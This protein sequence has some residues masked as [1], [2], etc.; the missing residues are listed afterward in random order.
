MERPPSPVSQLPPV[1]PRLDLLQQRPPGSHSA[2]GATAKVLT[3]SVQLRTGAAVTVGPLATRQRCVVA[4]P[5]TLP[6]PQVSATHRDKPL[7]LPPALRELP[8]PPP[9]ERP[10]LGGQDSRLQRRPLPS[11]PDQP[12][13]A[14]NYMVPRP[15]NKV[16]VSPLPAAAAAHSGNNGEGSKAQVA[17]NAVYCLSARYRGP[18]PPRCS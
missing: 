10:L 12:S 4:L 2:Q 14:S 6:P 15:V 1:P 7:P 16:S 5:A 3:H 17:T 18:P 11:T 8:P 9:P 13:W